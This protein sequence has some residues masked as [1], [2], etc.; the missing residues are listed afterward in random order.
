MLVLRGTLDPLDRSAR[1]MHFP[2]DVVVELEYSRRPKSERERIRRLA[3][4][5]SLDEHGSDV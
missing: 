4:A 3:R 2:L 1:P 5:W